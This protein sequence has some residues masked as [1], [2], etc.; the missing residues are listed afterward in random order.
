MAKTVFDMPSGDADFDNLEA[1]EKMQ[2]SCMI[3]KEGKGKACL[4]SVDGKTIPGYSDTDDEEGESEEELEEYVEDEGSGIKEL[5][6][7]I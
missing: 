5:E 1:G 4:V 3:R 7:E 6:D 2:V